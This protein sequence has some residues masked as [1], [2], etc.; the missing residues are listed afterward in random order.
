METIQ[1]EDFYRERD[2][3]RRLA[4][5]LVGDSD[6][7][8]IVQ[9]AMAA[10]LSR[11]VPP[12]HWGRWLS[13]VTR[14][15]S[16]RRSTERRA[17]AWKL[18]RHARTE[19][20]GEDHGSSTD[21]LVA[22]VE[23]KNALERAVLDLDEPYRSVLLWRYYED[24][25]IEEISLR[26]GTPESTTRTRIERGLKRL[27]ARMNSERGPEWRMALVPLLMRRPAETTLVGTVAS[28][29]V[30]LMTFSML[31]WI[32]GA[33]AAAALVA[34]LANLDDAGPPLEELPGVSVQAAGSTELASV[35]APV[36]PQVREPEVRQPVAT[37]SPEP[38]AAGPVESFD[39][40]LEDR[41]S[42]LALAGIELAVSISH[43]INA[44]ILQRT[45]S[46]E[47]T[48]LTDED[49]R[50]LLP[51]SEKPEAGETRVQRA[52]VSVQQ[53]GP[54]K[55]YCESSRDADGTWVFTP[56]VDFACRV[57][58]PVPLTE[59]QRAAAT[60]GLSTSNDSLG[61]P[62]TTRFRPAATLEQE[63]TLLV[64]RSS[65]SR[66]WSEGESVGT[67]AIATT[68]GGPSFTATFETLPSF[69][70]DPLE[71]ELSDTVIHSVRVVDALTGRPVESATVAVAPATAKHAL[72]EA[73]IIGLTDAA[74]TTELI[75]VPTAEPTLTVQANYYQRFV[76][77]LRATAG[78][79]TEVLLQPES[80]GRPV[81][82]TVRSSRGAVPGYIAC[83]VTSASGEAVTRE[84]GRPEPSGEGWVFRTTLEKVPA[85]RCSIEVDL[86]GTAYGCD[87][88]WLLE[89]AE[90]SL[91]IDLGEAREVLPVL[92]DAPEGVRF[93]YYQGVDSPNLFVSEHEGAGTV[94]EAPVD[95]TPVTWKV[96]A[97]G[98]VPMIGT[99]VDWTVEDQGGRRVVKLDADFE[100]GWGAA[101]RIARLGSDDDGRGGTLPFDLRALLPVPGV[102]LRDGRDGAEIGVTNDRGLA[103][104]R[105]SQRPEAFWV[106][107]GGES[108]RWSTVEGQ[109]SYEVRL[110][111]VPPK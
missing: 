51:G 44:L 10:A 86:M 105:A 3:I 68:P 110:P 98:Y 39:S 22:E 45:L 85:E 94:R 55:V 30:M 62:L 46:F 104:I 50:F 96:L 49:G 108:Y 16:W 35:E 19:G 17:R 60:Y 65:F 79:T 28:S 69:G 100:P 84:T 36:A 12:L 107:S 61:T 47:G 41:E 95:G 38:A 37:P 80:G 6:A 31:K 7:D 32:V 63:L 76:G 88:Y 9:E 25:S 93:K 21:E 77:S 23:A 52:E 54:L 71:A 40:R 111:D 57:H 11:E 53:D 64:P 70:D 58:L 73:A 74:G 97:E 18:E 33:T 92:V 14:H 1:I 56:I 42:G 72:A 103:V 87:G 109:L 106:L 29:G 99:E 20:L 24:L 43:T 27:R 67:I 15:L 34:A 102:V 82:L 90:S 2:R 26:S 8:D 78:G 13:G 48:V 66:D 59:E 75:H 81:E 4:C 101:V 91:T 89:P 5:A 83:M